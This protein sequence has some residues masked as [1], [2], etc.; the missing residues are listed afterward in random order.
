MKQDTFIEQDS[1]QSIEIWAKQF[2]IYDTP[3]GFN[4]RISHYFLFFGK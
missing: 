3:P 1:M 2:L 4:G